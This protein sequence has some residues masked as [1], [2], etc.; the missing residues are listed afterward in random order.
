VARAQTAAGRLDRAA[1]AARAA[2][3]TIDL[4]AARAPLPALRHTFEEWA[5]VQAAREDLH[6]ILR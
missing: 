3:G 6:R 1:E 5:R 4:V 2:L